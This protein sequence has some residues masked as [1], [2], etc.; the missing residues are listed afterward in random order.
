MLKK[1]VAGFLL[2]AGRKNVALVRKNRPDW[3]AGLLNG[4]GGK[5]E[6]AESYSEAM[7]REFNEEAGVHIPVNKWERMCTIRWGNDHRVDSEGA[8]VA[9]FRHVWQGDEALE[10]I[11][12][13][14]TD[15]WIEVW[16]LDTPNLPVIPNLK[17]L[18]P[19][20]AY[21]ADHYSHFFV[22]A[23]VAVSVND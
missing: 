23:E 12:T 20:A 22:D 7:S 9:F 21:E 16:P 5:V 18:L 19:L 6:Y 17:W 8:A 2:D 13:A 10:D 3:Q 4:I 1:Y 14:M 15:E 11:V